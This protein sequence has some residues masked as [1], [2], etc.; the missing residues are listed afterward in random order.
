MQVSRASLYHETNSLSNHVGE[1]GQLCVDVLCFPLSHWTC[2]KLHAQDSLASPCKAT[3]SFFSYVGENGDLCVD[4]CAPLYHSRNAIFDMFRLA[5]RRPAMKGTHCAGSPV[6]KNR[7]RCVDVLRR[8]MQT[9]FFVIC[10]RL[11]ASSRRLPMQ[12]NRSVIYPGPPK[13]PSAYCTCA[14][15]SA[16]TVFH[17][18]F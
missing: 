2:Y 12:T 14:P 9:H 7:D 13:T 11:V 15:T 8:P 16:T 6:S 3:N 5:G 10:Q 18:R 1:N 17:V 4:A